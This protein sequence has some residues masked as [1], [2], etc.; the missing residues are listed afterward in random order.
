MTAHEYTI[1]LAWE[2][3]TG[4]GTADYASYSRQFRAV[5][6]GK[7]AIVGSA[8]PSFRGD[9]RLIDPETMLV[10]SLSS[11]HMLSYLALCALKKISV[12]AYRD[13]ATGTMRA[14]RNRGRFD[15]VVLRPH[16]VIAEG[17]DLEAARSLH[18][19]A[20]EGCY[21]AS[22]VNFPVRHA[23]T[24]VHG[25]VSPP[26]KRVD[27]SVTLGSLA[28]FTAQLGAAGINIEGGGAF[29]GVAHFLVD[30]SDKLADLDVTVRSA[31]THRLDQ[32]KP[33]SLAA[34]TAALEQAGVAIEC[35]YSD[36]DHQLILVVDDEAKARASLS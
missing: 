23:A 34:L 26:T 28:E 19:E 25:T 36:H 10:M 1:A 31:I 12:L 32:E 35:M 6:P 21:I 5:A 8:D 7:A 9:K 30:D 17:A 24:V 13:T 33:G 29:G 15:E 11:C 16:V 2:G 3:N 14:D 27:V 18:H 20:H 4:R 22:S